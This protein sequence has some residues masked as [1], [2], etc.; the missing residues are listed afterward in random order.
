MLLALI[1]NLHAKD[2]DS[3]RGNEDNKKNEQSSDSGGN[4]EEKKDP[5]VK[6]GGLVFSHWGYML[7]EAS[8]GYNEFALDRAYLIAQ[9]K[10]EHDFGVRLTLDADHMK[11][12]ATDTGEF[13]YD[14]KYRVFIKHAYLEWAPAGTG[15]KVRGGVVDTPYAP[16]Y[17]NFWGQR[18]ISESFGAGNKI[19]GMS[20]ADLGVAVSGEQGK[21]LI[22]WQI[23]LVNGE[24]YSK[25]EVDSGKSIQGRLTIDPMARPDKYA[26]PISLY[27]ADSSNA[28]AEN[29]T[30]TFGGALGF[31]MTNLWFWSEYLQSTTDEV[32]SGGFSITALPRMPRYGALV[33]RYGRFDPDQ[34]NNG[35][36]QDQMIV[37]VSHDFMEKV[38]LAATYESTSFEDDALDPVSGIFL[39]LQAG[40]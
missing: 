8:D 6:V 1:L 36:Y 27:F 5:V 40:F 31:K 16:Y 4:K 38:S 9:A 17:D 21:G 24:G 19:G 11:P 39:H 25:L 10:L 37:G 7:G 35:D 18:F 32:S 28:L 15:V 2:S 12:V 29:S 13:S 30:I 3:L 34:D 26:L 14:T 22:N 23:D 20:T 33:F